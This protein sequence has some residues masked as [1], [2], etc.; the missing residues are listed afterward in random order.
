MPPTMR[1]LQY[2]YRPRQ[3]VALAVLAVLWLA[4]LLLAFAGTAVTAGADVAAR[5]ITTAQ[6]RVLTHPLYYSQ[7]AA[8]R[9]WR[10]R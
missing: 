9:V 8:Q 2:H 7:P 3:L 5:G 4:L 6:H 1:P 10:V